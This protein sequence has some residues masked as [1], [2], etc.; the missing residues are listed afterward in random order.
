MKNR[1]IYKAL[2][3]VLMILNIH[4]VYAG[5][6]LSEVPEYEP[7]NPIILSIV[8]WLSNSLIVFAAFG[9]AFKKYWIVNFKFWCSV[10]LIDVFA[11]GFSVYFEFLAGGYAEDEMI[12]VSLV[13]FVV[14]CV[15][16]LAPLRYCQDI[17]GLC[18][19][20]EK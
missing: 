17:R 5:Y 8:L 3:T 18:L 4:D 10:V 15:Y 6:Q 11:S 1:F 13:T 14:L 7:S 2:F 20:R 12:G 19:A 9:A 16:L